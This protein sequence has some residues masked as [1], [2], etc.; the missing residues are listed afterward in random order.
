MNQMN[1]PNKTNQKDQTNQIDQMNQTDYTR[2][3][4]WAQDSTSLCRQR[5]CFVG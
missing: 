1:Q 2:S 3:G 4:K 5:R